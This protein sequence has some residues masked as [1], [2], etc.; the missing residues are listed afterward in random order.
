MFVDISCITE[1]SIRFFASTLPT[2]ATTSCSA[3]SSISCF[4]AFSYA[5]DSSFISVTVSHDAFV[6]LS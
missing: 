6:W 4:T 1:S 5:A 3:V 2:V